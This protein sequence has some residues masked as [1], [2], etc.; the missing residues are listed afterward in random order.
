[1]RACERDSG[2]LTFAFVVV[3]ALCVCAY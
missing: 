3:A 2:A 1:V